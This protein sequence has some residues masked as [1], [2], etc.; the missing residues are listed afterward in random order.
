MASVSRCCDV[1]SFEKMLQYLNVV[2]LLS[3]FLDADVMAFMSLNL[4]IAVFCSCNLD[5]MM[6]WS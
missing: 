4:D 1:A 6:L 2:A 3:L 5:I